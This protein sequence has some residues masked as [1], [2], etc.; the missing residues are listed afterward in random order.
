MRPS[1]PEERLLPGRMPLGRLLLFQAAYWLAAAFLLFLYGLQYGHWQVAVLRHLYFPVLAF[2]MSFAM[3]ATYRTDWFRAQDLPFL[4]A[5]VVSALAALATALVLN[6]VTFALAESGW[7]HRPVRILGTDTLY[8]ALFYFVW[9]LIFMRLDHGARAH[10][11]AAGNYPEKL[12]VGAG[13]DLRVLHLADV[14]CLRAERDYVEL[15]TAEKGYLKKASLSGLLEQIDPARFVRVHR[16]VAVNRAK[17]TCVA[18]LGRGTFEITLAS[19]R[20]VASSR[21]Y[22][23]VVSGLLP[24]A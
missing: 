9:S 11:A 21:A 13:D 5:G 1:H 10:K 16:S 19:G 2:A 18:A 15:V 8:F 22:R 4:W 20:K 24:T 3:A 7:L 12:K 6:P 23:E 17:V 14:E